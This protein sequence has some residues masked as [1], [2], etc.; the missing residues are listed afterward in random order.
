MLKFGILGLGQAGSNIAEYAITKG[1]TSVA[2][3]TAKVDLNLLKYVP[4]ENRL[5]L[6]GYNG[7]GRN[8]DIGKEAI[9]E[10]AEALFELCKSKFEDCDVVFV[11][12]AGGGGTGSGALPVAVD[13]L[14]EMF[15]VVN[16]IFVLPDN[17]ES[18]SS[19]MNAYDCFS[20]LSEN[21]QVGS[22]FI[23]DNQKGKDLIP[24]DPKFKVHKTINKQIIDILYEINQLTE[25]F[26]YTNNFDDRDLLDILYTRGC[27]LISKAVCNDNLYSDNDVSSLIRSSWTETYSPVYNTENILKAAILGKIHHNASGNINLEQ[28]FNGNCPYDIKDSLYEPQGDQT[29]FYSIFSGLEFPQDRLYRMKNDIEKVQESLIKRID[30]SQNQKIN[31]VDWKINAPRIDKQLQNKDSI[32]LSEKLKKFK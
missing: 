6:N 5:F 30:T 32:S 21:T 26:S 7:A 4:A 18:P 1:F 31:T 13:I 20:Q 28:I 27:T 3:N 19:K 29:C 12:A 2:V 22:I 10:N 15:S 24:K 14:L 11:A 23:I 16:V 17:L 8:R 9:V 25:R